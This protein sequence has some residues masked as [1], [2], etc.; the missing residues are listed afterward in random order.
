MNSGTCIRA[1][2]LYEIVFCLLHVAVFSITWI[3]YLELSNRSSLIK[4]IIIVWYVPHTAYI[5][6]YIYAYIKLH[7]WIMASKKSYA[8]IAHSQY[9]LPAYS[10]FKYST[11][12]LCDLP[13]VPVWHTSETLSETKLVMR[14]FI[15][16]RQI[17]I[18]ISSHWKHDD[19]TPVCIILGN[20][21]HF[22]VIG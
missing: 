12:R 18:T 15:Y 9:N 21:F 4:K 6:T 20:I 1:R 3:C 8:W 16:N 22:A 13:H 10:S 19:V 2:I 7:I 5:H 11:P 14:H 17:T